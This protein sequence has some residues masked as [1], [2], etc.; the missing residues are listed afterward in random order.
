MNFFKT[1]IKIKTN[2]DDVPPK[3]AQSACR[4]CSRSFK[5]VSHLIQH[6][7]SAHRK[8]LANRVHG[9]GFA[10]KK[11]SSTTTRPSLHQETIVSKIK[12]C[13]FCDGAFI[14]NVSLQSHVAAAHTHI[15]TSPESLS[16]SSSQKETKTHTNFTKDLCLDKV[17][18]A[19]KKN[20]ST[21]KIEYEAYVK[22]ERPIK[23]NFPVV[24]SPTPGPS[25]KAKLSSDMPQ[26]LLNDSL[27]DTK[28]QTE[29]LKCSKCAQELYSIK[30][31]RRHIKRQHPEL[32][33]ES[34]PFKQC[35]Y[36][37]YDRAALQVHYM[38]AHNLD[39]PLFCDQCDCDYRAYLAVALAQHK[40]EH[41]Q[42]KIHVTAKLRNCSD[43]DDLIPH[44]ERLAECPY[45]GWMKLEKDLLDHCQKSECGDCESCFLC[46]GQYDEHDCPSRLEQDFDEFNFD[47]NISW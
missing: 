25:K 24:T 16:S 38:Y 36:F 26:N 22:L 21:S 44:D 34:C 45:C 9:S 12:F 41:N 4:F 28:K 39:G 17:C 18:D 14:N 19:S 11:A 7:R 23:W 8:Q 3:V 5:F 46:Q 33:H 40:A 37:C 29:K 30:G 2:D 15:K 31:L 10:R 32:G 6:A 42:S 20:C 13:E 47:V 43:G 27:P 1:V 35:S